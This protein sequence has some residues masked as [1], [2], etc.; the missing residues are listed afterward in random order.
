M[1]R[2]VLVGVVVLALAAFG[3]SQETTTTETE[4]GDGEVAVQLDG[5][6]T[7]F[8]GAFPAFFPG[9]LSAH[10]GETIAFKLPHFSGE[11]H[12][13]TLG[14]L[15]NAAA[16]KAD[17]LGENAK[18]EQLARLDDGPEMLKLPDIFFHRPPPGPPSPNQSAAQPCVV[19]TG[20][21][22][23]SLTGG[24][25]ACAQKTLGDFKGTE[26]FY[27]SGLLMEDGASFDLKLADDIKPGTYR[28]MCMLHR[29]GMRGTITVVPKEQSADSAADVRS[30]GRA[31]LKKIVDALT[32]VQP[33]LA[34]ATASNAL[35]GIGTPD[36]PDALIAEWGPKNLN[37]K[38]GETVSWKIFLFHNIA[39]NP[40]EGAVGAFTKGRDGKIEFNGPAAAA[41]NSPQPPPVTAFF[42]PPADAKPLTVNGGPWDGKAFRNSSIL[43][44]VKPLEITYTTTF[45]TAGT[46]QLRCLLHPDMKGTVTVT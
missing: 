26:A 35:S 42:P 28:M 44:S 37:V 33:Q 6:T 2:R 11:P 14:T 38:K 36:V 10:P 40:P 45:T 7:Q 1:G 21:P 15:V 29:A 31:E 25:P 23:L 43:G 34:K 18:F 12:T 32:E 19:Q 22:P 46:Y 41:I 9:K 3:C 8:N 24:A 17:S 4:G 27:N 20:T 16:A 39:L 5:Q 13:V 30:R